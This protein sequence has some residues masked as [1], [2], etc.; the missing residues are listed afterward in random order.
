VRPERS[1]K[2]GEG[3]VASEYIENPETVTRRFAGRLKAFQKAEH[4][5]ASIVRTLLCRVVGE[6][7]TTSR[8]TLELPRSHIHLRNMPLGIATSLDA[9]KII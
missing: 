1:T 2:P 3:P 9:E 4:A 7:T 6:A 5:D 8:R